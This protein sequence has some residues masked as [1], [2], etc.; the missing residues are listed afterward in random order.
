[1]Q[2]YFQQRGT[3]EPM[4]SCRI[5]GETA[6]VVKFTLALKESDFAACAIGQTLMM[7]YIR[8][9]IVRERYYTVLDN[10]GRKQAGT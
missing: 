3:K 7:V 5:R 4:S 1:M 2:C 10:R 8:G 9:K 6:R